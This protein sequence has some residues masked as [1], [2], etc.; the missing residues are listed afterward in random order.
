[1][2][3]EL[4]LPARD[5]MP[6]TLE[7]EILCFADDFHS[8][9]PIFI[10]HDSYVEYLEEELPLQVTRFKKAVGKFGIPDVEALA[11]KY[12]HPIK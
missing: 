2:K 12:D 5:Y 8:K 10:A 6:R 11:K 7:A 1:M 4:K 9:K 3:L